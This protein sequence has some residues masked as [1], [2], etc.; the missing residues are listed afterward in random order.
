MAAEPL[1][2]LCGG[3]RWRCLPELPE[4]S[5]PGPFQASSPQPGPA[6]P[7]PPYIPRSP[8][9]GLTTPCSRRSP[10][11]RGAGGDK[12]IPGPR[13]AGATKPRAPQKP[14]IAQTPK[15]GPGCR[16]AAILSSERPELWQQPIGEQ[17]GGAV[18]RDWAS[19]R[20]SPPPPRRSIP[21][22][23]TGLESSGFLHSICSVTKKW[24]SA[25]RL[26][27]GVPPPYS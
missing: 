6:V 16:A 12:P 5:E 17:P 26:R 23:P 19:G 14:G 9:S 1:P 8:H 4:E 13:W 10:K 11:S 18:R 7:V 21:A 27:S 3:F 25:S 22:P 20:E 15:R 24:A 2:E